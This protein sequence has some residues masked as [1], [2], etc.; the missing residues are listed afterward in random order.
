RSSGTVPGGKRG[1]T[2]HEHS[3]R[4]ETSRRL[5]SREE[6]AAKSIRRLVARG[7]LWRPKEQFGTGSGM[8]SV[9]DDMISNLVSDEEWA[10]AQHGS[11]VG[12]LPTPR[13]KEELVYQRMFSAHLDGIRPEVVGRFATT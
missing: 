5:W 10:H 8:E 7:L 12:N 6:A 1:A 11:R 3:C 13:S 9:M 4:M 2:C